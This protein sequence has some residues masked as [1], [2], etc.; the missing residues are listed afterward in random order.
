MEVG[1]WV[2]CGHPAVTGD[3]TSQSLSHHRAIDHSDEVDAFK[4]DAAQ[5]PRPY[6]AGQFHFGLL[7]CVEPSSFVSPKSF[8]RWRRLQSGA[9][10]SSSMSSG[11]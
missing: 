10:V 6:R 7:K 4:A 2:P 1:S 3:L 5:Q 11:A 8:S 9:V